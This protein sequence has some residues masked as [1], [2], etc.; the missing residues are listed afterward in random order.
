MLDPLL[1]PG[2]TLR[3]AGP[4]VSSALTEGQDGA[5]YDSRAAMYDRVVGNRVYNRM[6]WG[7]SPGLYTAF[8]EEAL[9]AGHGSYLDA[10][11][12]T[13][14][15]T[16]PV[17]ERASRPLVLVDLSLG[18]L[19]RAAE[20]VTGEQAAFVQAD[21]VRL[22]FAPG[23]FETVACFGVLHVLD[24]PEAVL[25]EL[26]GQLAPGGRLFASMLVTDR[27]VGGKYISA[28]RRRGEFG[29]PRREDELASM[30][31]EVFGDA[32]EV[33]RTGSMAWL[34]AG[35]GTD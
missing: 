8:A 4:R 20:K 22:P 7:T 24:D 26:H 28:L 23:K 13:C 31:R 2:R 16:A 18:M 9:A 21:L 27:A 32:A 19:H 3:P 35:V 29:P 17:Y 6:A 1:A 33:R 15:F 25:G 5:P 14:V 34:R 12:G 30:A 10:G 11:C